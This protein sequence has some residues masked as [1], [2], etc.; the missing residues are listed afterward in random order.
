MKDKIDFLI[1][2]IA[3]ILGILV[4]PACLIMMLLN[5]IPRQPVQPKET[6]ELPVN[7]SEDVLSSNLYSDWVTIAISGTGQID[8]KRWHTV[9]GTYFED[10]T[11]EDGSKEHFNG[12]I[13]DGEVIKW[14]LS[15]EGLPTELTNRELYEYTFP[16]RVGEEPRR[17]A[18]R[19]LNGNEQDTSTFTI[20]IWSGKFL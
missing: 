1:K 13:L 4:I 17:L 3:L 2:R 18:F 10:Q 20:V 9:F 5:S 8:E 7:T 11:F 12:F 16:Y 19:M 6:L 15:L 14:H